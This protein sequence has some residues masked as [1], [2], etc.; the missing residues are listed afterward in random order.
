VRVL[1]AG[2]PNA[3][4]LDDLAEFFLRL[5]SFGMAIL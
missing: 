1:L 3:E 5:L 4:S 2:G